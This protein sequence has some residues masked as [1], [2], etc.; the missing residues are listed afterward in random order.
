MAWPLAVRKKTE[1]KRGPPSLSRLRVPNEISLHR[2]C[3]NWF[4]VGEETR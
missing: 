1:E 3:A 2:T 4:P